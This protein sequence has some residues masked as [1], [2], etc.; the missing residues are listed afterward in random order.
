MRS[1][2]DLIDCSQTSRATIDMHGGTLNM[3]FDG[4]VLK[5]NIFNVMRFLT[6]V[7]YVCALE[8]IIELS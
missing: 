2:H 7:Q 6:N 3:E 5:F 4:E 8:L 1:Q